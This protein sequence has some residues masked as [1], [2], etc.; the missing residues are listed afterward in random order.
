MSFPRAPVE[1][2]A[3]TFPKRTHGLA[4]NFE[5]YLHPAEEL[6]AEEVA[7]ARRNG[8]FVGGDWFTWRFGSM[9]PQADRASVVF[10]TT[11]DGDGE[12]RGEPDEAALAATDA[13][14]RA[15]SSSLR[16]ASWGGAFYL[17]TTGKGFQPA[18]QGIWLYCLQTA[19]NAI[20]LTEALV[21]VAL[22]GNIGV[23]VIYQ[24]ILVETLSA[25]PLT[26]KHGKYLV[27]IS[28]I[29]YWE[30]AFIISA[31]VAAVCVFREIVLHG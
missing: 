23:K 1:A 17:I 26:A 16:T 18:N 14:Y 6:Q 13:E 19:T 29:I 5:T 12:R 7:E 31:L 10:A 20:S 24:T 22:Y 9:P 30:L 28:V 8:E 4:P 11:P 27:A 15:A 25:P 2:L 21:A 3:F